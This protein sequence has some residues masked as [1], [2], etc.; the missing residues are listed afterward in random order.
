MILLHQVE[1]KFIS[2][3]EVFKKRPSDES[4]VDDILLRHEN[5]FGQL[6]ENFAADKGFYKSMEKIRELEDRIANVSIA[7]KGSRTAAEIA[8]PPA[9]ESWVSRMT[10]LTASPANR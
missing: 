2:D 7:K 8:I 10:V 1:N 9:P 6:P 4:L 3:Y 5:Q